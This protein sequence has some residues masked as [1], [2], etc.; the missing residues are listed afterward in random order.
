M[1]NE[2]NPASPAMFAAALRVMRKRYQRTGD[3]TNPV[4]YMEQYARKYDL[5]HSQTS[6][7]ERLATDLATG[8][9]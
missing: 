7:M 5:T 3:P 2:K 1:A 8:K 6:T 4:L 9:A